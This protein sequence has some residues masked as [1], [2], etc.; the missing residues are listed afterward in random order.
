MKRYSRP[1]SNYVQWTYRLIAKIDFLIFGTIFYPKMLRIALAAISCSTFIQ[2]HSQSNDET[3]MAPFAA[4]HAENVSRLLK[5]FEAPTAPEKPVEIIPEW[6]QWSTVDNYAF[7]KNRG[8]M[9]MIADLDALH[10]YFRQKV[11][12]LIEACRAKGIELAIVETY[13]TRA[14]QNEYRSMGRIYTRSYGG[15]S[16]HQYGLAIDV[17]PIVDSV[18][19]WH[20]TALWKKVGM[21]GEKLGLRWGGR[22]RHPYDPG[23]F[24][25]TGGLN[26]SLLE[27][28]MFPRI[29][30][31]ESFPCLDEDLAM[32]KGWWEAW[33]AEQSTTA[34]TS[35]AGSKNAM[36]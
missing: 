31:K 10:P 14:K 7:G 32:L 6:R 4:E 20:N 17:V 26:S 25:W 18:A 5:A 1:G 8:A 16:K 11:L 28:G 30:D 23:H 34:G 27:Q 22:W 33:E 35:T 36:K 9:S 12:A 29:P 3:G 19:T 13:R 21:A 15:K 2:V 24:E